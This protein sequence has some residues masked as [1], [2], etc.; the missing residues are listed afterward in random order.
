MQHVFPPWLGQPNL[1]LRLWFWFLLF[2]A[3]MVSLVTANNVLEG[4]ELNSDEVFRHPAGFVWSTSMALWLVLSR[5]T[6]HSKASFAVSLG[7]LLV[8]AAAY[9]FFA[10]GLVE[11]GA[12]MFVFFSA[13]ALIAGF[14]VQAR[15]LLV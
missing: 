15:R 2:L 4:A 1:V 12:L 6:T 11:W 8:T 9:T 14:Y 13:C 5:W 3:I 10:F 7:L